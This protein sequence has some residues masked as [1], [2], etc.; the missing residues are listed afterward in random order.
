MV[1]RNSGLA[2][3]GLI[4]GARAQLKLALEIHY[5]VVYL[6]SCTTVMTRQLIRARHVPPSFANAGALINLRDVCAPSTSS[7]RSSGWLRYCGSMMGAANGSAERNV[8]L[9]EKEM[10]ERKA[11]QNNGAAT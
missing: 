6:A 5:G 3:D 2:N 4:V 10:R 11:K 8:T 7:R 9:P 1:N